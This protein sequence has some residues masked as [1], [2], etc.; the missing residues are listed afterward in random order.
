LDNGKA[1]ASAPPPFGTRVHA[2]ME[3]KESITTCLEP[4]AR[5]AVGLAKQVV[6]RIPNCVESPFL[7]CFQF[8]N[9]AV[10]F[11]KTDQQLLAST[12]FSGECLTKRPKGGRISCRP[13]WTSGCPIDQSLFRTSLHYLMEALFSFSLLAVFSIWG[14][15]GAHSNVSIFRICFPQF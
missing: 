12:H 3:T 1:Q 9:R 11:Q 7:F 4:W 15:V 6:R 14:Q 8:A 5:T 2:K 13:F 10:D